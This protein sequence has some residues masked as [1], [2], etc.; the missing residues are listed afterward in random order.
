MFHVEHSF[1]VARTFPSAFA[2][3]GLSGQAPS[4]KDGAM[5]LEA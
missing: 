1:L 4:A 5:F 2:S 3:G